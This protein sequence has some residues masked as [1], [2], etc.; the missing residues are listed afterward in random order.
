M[1]SEEQQ[2]FNELLEQSKSFADAVI[3]DSMNGWY[4]NF[5]SMT[6]PQV[7]Q[8]SY[9]GKKIIFQHVEIL[10][11]ANCLCVF[12]VT[13]EGY[14]VCCRVL[15]FYPHIFCSLPQG[16]NENKNLDFFRNMLNDDMDAQTDRK[17][18]QKRIRSIEYVRRRNIQFYENQ[19]AAPQLFLKITFNSVYGVSDFS[20]YL[21][22]STLKELKT[23]KFFNMVSDPIT[24]FMNDTDMKGGC[25][26]ELRPYTFEFL[27]SNSYLE[28]KTDTFC[29]INVIV[30]VNDL[31]VHNPNDVWTSIANFRILSFDIECA[32]RRGVFPQH[33]I[34]PV[35]QIANV[36]YLQGNDQP[37]I[38][39]VFVLNSCKPVDDYDVWCFDS[40]AKLLDKW[41]KFVL[42]VDPD[43][44]TGYNIL[45]F[46]LPYLVNRAAKLNV[47]F[48]LNRV[49]GT[50]TTVRKINRASKQYGREE[51][52][53][54]S[55]DGRIIFDLFQ[56]L[57][58]EH[59]LRSFSLNAVAYHFLKEKK[60]DVHHSMI[61]DLHNQD[62]D[63]R[64]RLAVYCAKDAYLP[65]KLLNKLMCIINYIEMARV[66]GVP[67][68]YLL[69]RGQQVRIFSLLLRAANKKNLI[70]P[71]NAKGVKNGVF[72][73]ATV[74]EPQ[75]GFYKNPIATLDFASLY[76]SI[77]I[78]HNLCYTS[79][80]FDS[81]AAN[82]ARLKLTEA[83]IDRTPDM[84]HAFVH[85]SIHKGILPDILENLLSARKKAKAELK[86]ETD[87][88]KKNVL[89][90]RQLALKVSANS[91]Y[92]FTGAQAGLLPCVAISA[93]VTSY[94]RQ[95]IKQTSELVTQYYQGS[96][97]IYGDTDSV[98]VNFGNIPREKAMEMGKEAATRVSKT[99]KAPIKL[100]FE[101]VYHPYLLINKKRYAGL[102][103]T[104]PEKHD[105]IDCKGKNK[106]SEFK[107]F[108]QIYFFI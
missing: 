39:N 84:P 33:E 20:K 34:D 21:S 106:F 31:I 79:L 5:G 49:I 4:K 59:K 55:L 18:F 90:G 32:G 38:R 107:F 9:L 52:T 101:K 25:W 7:D 63:G 99:F 61:T 3:L 81:S 75:R 80:L 6:R 1:S 54:I 48:R 77:M 72:E 95:M 42:A 35:I 98:M 100:E 104:R 62:S 70:I 69:N 28:K 53:F 50:E 103:F 76:P 85:A 65:V 78:A 2:N 83:D 43:F 58:R 105:K 102:L 82:L 66:T 22:K 93:S 64:H 87:P 56:I 8:N 19:F 89:D 51:L 15:E 11:M 44:M 26:L 47:D 13:Q 23:V 24:Q 97:V 108:L 10:K 29:Q 14:S 92:G 88:M 68:S 41:A 17:N 96:V 45:N 67:I 37:F 71:H 91:V 27:F 16:Y 36:V 73:G 86:I 60:E 74:I 12:G 40:E 46:D 30:K 94:G 57:K